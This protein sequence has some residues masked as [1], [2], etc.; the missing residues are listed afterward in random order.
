[1]AQIWVKGAPGPFTTRKEGVV[2]NIYDPGIS[3]NWVFFPFMDKLKNA[4]GGW[5]A[6]ALVVVVACLIVSALMLAAGHWWDHGRSTQAGKGGIIACFIAAALIG[7][8]S[9]AVGFFGNMGLF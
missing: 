8:A 3:P 6:T 4:V 5:Q 9:A 7:T 1:M 2:V